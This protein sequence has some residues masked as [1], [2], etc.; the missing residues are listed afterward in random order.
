MSKQRSGWPTDGD[1]TIWQAIK[2]MV[3]GLFRR[4]RK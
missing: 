1:I 3:L 2:L 4:K